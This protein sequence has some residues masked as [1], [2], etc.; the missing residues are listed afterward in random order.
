MGLEY[1]WVDENGITNRLRIDD[2]DPIH[3]G[4]NVANGW[5]AHR[6]DGGDYTCY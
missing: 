4:S 5:I 1:K 6:A 3:Y 2:S